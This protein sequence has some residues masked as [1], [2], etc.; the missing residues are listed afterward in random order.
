MSKYSMRV[1]WSDEDQMLVATCPELSEISALG[2]T[3]EEA[4]AELQIAIELAVATYEDEGKPLPEPQ[5]LESHSGQFRL[6]LPKSMHASLAERADQEGVSLNTLII[7]LL[8]KAEGFASG[9]SATPEMQ[10]V[11]EELRMAM[12]QNVAFKQE[13]SSSVRRAFKPQVVD[14]RSKSPVGLEKAS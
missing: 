12:A 11:L 9:S 2:S 14:F 4:V 6:R 13:A 3:Y 7:S 8:S 5:R 10:A 1:A